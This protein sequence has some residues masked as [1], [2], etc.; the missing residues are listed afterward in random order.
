MARFL[1]SEPHYGQRFCDHLLKD[2]IDRD[3]ILYLAGNKYVTI[4]RNSESSN[5]YA[6][7]ITISTIDNCCNSFLNID[8]FNTLFQGLIC[9]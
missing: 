9:I 5:S 3:T 4:H 2:D 7:S 6:I 8:S 1:V